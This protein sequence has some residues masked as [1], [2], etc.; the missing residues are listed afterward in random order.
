MAE[1]YARALGDDWIEAKSA[2]LVAQAKDARAIA[3]IADVDRDTALRPPMLVTPDMVSW[4]DLVVT[5]SAY[6][7]EHCP[8]LPPHAQKKHWLLSDPAPANSGDANI[9][10]NYAALRDDIKSRVQG[11]IGGIRMISK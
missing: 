6:A 5:V 2:G 4:A 9:A 7:D 3:M 1:A 8:A 10:A 11:L